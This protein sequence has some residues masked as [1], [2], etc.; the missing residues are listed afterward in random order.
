MTID[1]NLLQ[2]AATIVAAKIGGRAARAP[3]GHTPAVSITYSLHD[4]FVDVYRELERAQRTLREQD[5]RAFDALKR[6]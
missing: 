5:V 3:T 1:T 2:A 4:E 6:E